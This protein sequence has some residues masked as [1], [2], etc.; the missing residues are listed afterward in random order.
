MTEGRESQKLCV[1]G[2]AGTG[3][4][5]LSPLGRDPP[6]QLPTRV[7]GRLIPAGA[8]AGARARGSCR[9]AAPPAPFPLH[10]TLFNVVI[11][12]F[13]QFRH[14]LLPA[15]RTEPKLRLLSA[16]PPRTGGTS[17]PVKPADICLLIVHRAVRGSDPEVSY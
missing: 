3:L 7:R 10:R 6:A 17:H 2:A 8:S 9:G 13:I 16:R 4:R 5:C 14:K 15:R 1:K 12:E 11:L